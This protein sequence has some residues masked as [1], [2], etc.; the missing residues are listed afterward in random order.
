MKKLITVLVILTIFATT[1]SPIP[2]LAMEP[3]ETWAIAVDGNFA[4]TQTAYQAMAIIA[5]D[6]LSRPEDLFIDADG[7]L[8]VA[9]S[10]L[11]HIAIF[12]Q[13]RNFVRTVGTGVLNNPTGVFVT[14]YIF[15]ADTDHVFVF[16]MNGQLINQFGRPDSPLFG[17]TQPFRPR[18]IAVD[19]R[20]NIYIVGEA[21]SNGI[22]QLNAD[23]EFLGYF[24]A[25]Q[26]QLSFFQALQRFFNVGNFRVLPSAPSNLA[27]ADNG[28]VFTVTTHAQ[29]E[30]L[31]K[32]NIAGNNMFDPGWVF[33]L[34]P[35]DIALGNQGN[36][37]MI[38]SDGFI[39]EYDS[40]ANILFVFGGQDPHQHRFGVIHQPSSIEVGPDGNLYVADSESGLIHVFMPTE[41]ANTVHHALAYFEDG[42]YT[43]SEHYWEAVLRM[44][45]SFALAHTA[46]GQSQFIQG[47]YQE[48]LDRFYIALN[49]GG[50]SEA[51]WEIRHEWMLN[52][53]G[54]VLVLFIVFVVI[55]ALL[56]Q[57]DKRTGRISAVKTAIHQKID[58]PFL[59]EFGM[60]RRIFKQ[61]FD[62]FYEIKYLKLGSLK[63]ATGLYVVMFA[64]VFIVIH[65]AG[66]IFATNLIEEMGLLLIT[67]IFIGGFGLFLVIN[68]LISTITDGEGSF[69]D[70]YVATAFSMTPFI[71]LAIPVTLLSRVLTLN[72]G[73]VYTFL[74]QIAIGWSALLIFLM[75]KEIH[76][77]SVSQTIKNLILTVSGGL[78][79][80]IIGFILYIL[81][82]DQVIDFIYAIIWEVLMRV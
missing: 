34:M 4:P 41:F 63:F 26:A 62:V 43:Q 12:D 7:H 49:V 39:W 74:M 44:N 58:S 14:D 31:R 38:T 67:T 78:I 75:V 66:F 16:S 81:I 13:D 9:D 8:F 37:Y 48:A 46:I 36:F 42:L 56:K 72:E 45:S 53:L 73:F 5:D 10:H 19:V 30:R 51:F 50:Y 70:L 76:D 65:F 11:G 61:P 47:N 23:G 69:R 2:V 17:R 21:A 3:A 1:F 29:T 15:V 57:I 25:N 77:F 22:I 20:G 82:V 68:Y 18:K 52:N 27:I 54:R 40:S 24:G 79:S 71:L 33:P 28:V 64:M 55:N 60:M 35:I 59:R 80:V 32:L 6:H